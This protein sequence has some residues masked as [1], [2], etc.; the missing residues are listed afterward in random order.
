MHLQLLQIV[1][2]PLDSDLEP[3]SVPFTPGMVNVVMG[4]S[5]TGKSAVIPIIDYCLGAG[6]CAIPKRAIRTA[7]S[8]FGVVVDTKEGQKLFARRNSFEAESSG[9]MYVEES[10]SI[11]IPDRV[12]APNT[13]VEAVKKKLDH[14]AALTSL[15]FAGGNVFTSLDYRPSF[16]DLMAFVFQPQ[17]I[18]ANRDVLFYRTE[19]HEHREKLRKNILPYVIGA[20]T[21]QTLAAQ[22]ELDR[23]NRELRRKQRDF[24]RA[25]TT[26]SRWEA[27]MAGHLSRARELGLVSGESGT[28]LSRDAMLALL[29]EAAKKT[30]NEFRADSDTISKAVEDLMELEA[31]DSELAEELSAIKARQTEIERLRE[32]AGGFREALLLQRDRLK[33]SEWMVERASTSASCPMCDVPLAD[34]NQRVAELAEKLQQI[35]ATASQIVEVPAAIDREVQQIGRKVDDVAERLEAVRRQKRAL[36]ENSDEAR[37]RQFQWLGAAHFLGELSQALKLYEEVSDQSDLSKEINELQGRANE[38][39]KQ[40]DAEEI[41]RRKEAAIQKI[42]AYISEFMPQLDNDHQND[43]ARLVIEDL[44]LRI[45]AEEGES[46]LWSIGSGSNW[47][48]YHLA[49]MLALQSYFLDAPYSSVPG[50]LIFDQPSQVY[51]PERISRRGAPAEAPVWNNDEDSKAV[52]SAFQL[53]GKVVQERGGKLQIIVLDHAPEDVWGDLPSVTLSANWRT[54]EKLVPPHWPGAQE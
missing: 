40:I 34:T 22:H 32:G 25:K 37:K 17:N 49:T 53:L 27:E 36:E 21:P 42:A 20:V 31:K 41:E 35:E 39:L 24:E 13:N 51:F 14:L 23:I 52:R 26:S 30:V 11:Q 10:A 38:L 16:R 8:W 50:L 1:L 7:C 47:L 45:S 3:R 43:V 48:S 9:E 12:P 19:T 6:T 18:V 29:K 46:Y 4:G 5:R 2:W 28:T 33:I 15:D 54:G 44:T